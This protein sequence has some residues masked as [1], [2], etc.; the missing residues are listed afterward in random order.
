MK[1]LVIILFTSYFALPGQGIAQTLLYNIFV[2]NKQA[3]S[4]L[5]RAHKQDAQ[6]FSVH[7]ETNISVA[8]SKAHSV[9]RAQYQDG[10]LHKASMIQKVNDK[11]R[12][13]SEVVRSGDQ[14][15]ITIKGEEDVIL[16]RDVIYSVA[17]LYHVEPKDK[18]AVFSERFGVFC[19]IK[20]VEPSKYEMEM[21]DGKKVYYTYNNGICTQMRTKQMM[22]EVRFELAQR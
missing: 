22:M 15:H 9:L 12:E 20:E 6:N 16:K 19:P 3:G 17:L 1:T 10:Q 21:P 13:S 5:I 18:K 8:F 4:M 7:S 2:A 11:V 14:Y